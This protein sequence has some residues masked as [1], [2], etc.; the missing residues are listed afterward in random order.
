MIGVT[1][2]MG[3]QILVPL[4]KEKFVLIS[5]IV[6]AIV[7]LI[8]N[9][10]LIPEY[11]CTGAALGTLAAEFAVLVVQTIALRNLVFDILRKVKL[12][13]IV[14]SCAIAWGGTFAVSKLPLESNLLMLLCTFFVFFVIYAGVLLIL[15]E[16]LMSETIVQLKNKVLKR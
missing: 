3:I 4:G 14:L 5:E 1:N 9:A 13:K 12:L 2:I 16:P 15:K 7:D 6:G 11:G 10:L 8:L